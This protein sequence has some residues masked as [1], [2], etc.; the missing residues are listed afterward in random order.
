M[1]LINQLRSTSDFT[2]VKRLQHTSPLIETVP[3]TRPW[4]EVPQPPSYPVI[5]NGNLFLKN[6]N[7]M[8][9]L[10]KG[11]RR[12]YGDIYKTDAFGD[13]L[14]HIH[15]PRDAQT[16]I[17]NEGSQPIIPGFHQL[18]EFRRTELP[19]Y[20]SETTGLVS[21][22]E[23]WSNFR[24][25]VQQ[26]MMRSGSALLYIEELE[27]IAEELVEKLAEVKDNEGKI[28]IAE[29][30]KQFALESTGAIFLGS[31]LGVLNG[32][33]TGKAM[34]EHVDVFTRKSLP[35]FIFPLSVSNGNM[36]LF[37]YSI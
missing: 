12:E 24:Q 11:L 2:L 17:N 1:K 28:E 4:S 32:S 15:N 13:M 37:R 16:L 20:F 29:Y 33:E 6:M 9:K 7:S 3:M 8:D 21:E 34:I 19:T 30:M 18:A 27:N 36:M 22:G 31:R 25:L 35:L 5:G 10:H 23:E 14:L 26:D